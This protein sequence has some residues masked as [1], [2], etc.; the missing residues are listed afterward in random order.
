MV[1]TFFGHKDAS[2]CIYEDLRATIIKLTNEGVKDFFVGNNGNYDYM[3]Q[4]AL[5]ELIKNGYNS[6]R[7]K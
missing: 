2:E 6:K 5:V 3:V 7:A 1:C 4:K